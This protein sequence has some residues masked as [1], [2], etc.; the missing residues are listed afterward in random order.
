M[1]Y[2]ATLFVVALALQTSAC[3]WVTTKHEGQTLRKDV[4]RIDEIQ[5]AQEETMGSSVDKLKSTLDE[6]SKLLA[7]NNA[8]LGAQFDELEQENARLTGLVMEAKRLTDGIYTDVQRFDKRIDDLETRLAE[9]EGKASAPAPAKSPD[10]LYEEGM[11]ALT[12]NDYFKAREI[13]RKLV[14]KYPHHSRA[15]DAQY[16]RGE[17]Y[18]VQQDY[19]SAVKEYQAVFEKFGSSS[20]ADDALFRAGEASEKLKQ[21]IDARAYYG[22]LQQRYP[23]SSKASAAKKKDGYLKKRLKNRKYCRD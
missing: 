16:H 13:F 15:D 21:C 8:D 23:K 5:N 9:L 14:I 20:L 10:A 18:Y 7:R 17:S 1:K 11:R 2:T 12:A 19:K 22:L 6:A 4:N 3:F